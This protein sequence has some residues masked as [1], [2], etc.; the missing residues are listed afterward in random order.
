MSLCKAALDVGGGLNKQQKY[1]W[2]RA[3]LKSE[4]RDLQEVFLVLYAWMFD[5]DWNS[6]FWAEGGPYQYES[7]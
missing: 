7:T 1:Y 6:S 2:L 4:A 5:L 3:F